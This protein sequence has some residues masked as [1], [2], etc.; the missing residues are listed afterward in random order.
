SLDDAAALCS[1][2]GKEEPGLRPDAT[3]LV[4]GGLGGVG[5]QLARWLAEQGAR[6][7]LLVGRSGA[8]TP[9]ARRGIG[10]LER[11]GVLV[12]ARA[13]DVSRRADVESLIAAVAPSAPLRGVF[14]AAMVLDDGL[15][16]HLDRERYEKVL[17]PKAAGAWH[18]HA[19]TLRLPL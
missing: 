2:A 6:H 16:L 8:A 10:L 3:Y 17:L 19:A 18:L 5:L 13:A 12:R 7:L 15:A 11:Q 4:T 9:E 1:A 14:H